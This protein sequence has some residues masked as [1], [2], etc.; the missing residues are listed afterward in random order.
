[1]IRKP[2]STLTPAAGYIRMS[3]RTQDKSPAEQRAEITKLATREGSASS[4][5][6]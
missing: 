1:M 4:L 6:H 2:E 3:G 5:V